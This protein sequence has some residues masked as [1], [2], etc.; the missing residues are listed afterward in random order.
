MARTD[1][2][3]Y[4]DK[5]EVRGEDECWPWLASLNRYGYGQFRWD[6]TVSTSH[7]FGYTFWTGR[8]IPAGM[9]VDHVAAKCGHTWC[10]NPHH[11]ELVTKPEN[12]R[13]GNTNR[14]RVLAFA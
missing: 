1:A 4:L 13:R 8:E 12:V 7:R 14:R 6:G 2:E 10:Q 9:E 11:F 5:V 3:R